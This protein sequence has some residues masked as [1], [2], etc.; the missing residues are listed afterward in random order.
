MYLGVITIHLLGGQP[1]AP[2]GMSALQG[3]ATELHKIVYLTLTTHIAGPSLPWLF[4]HRSPGHA[5]KPPPFV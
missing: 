4:Q 2:A 3:L 1:Q 5:C